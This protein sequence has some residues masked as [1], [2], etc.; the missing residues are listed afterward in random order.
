MAPGHLRL[1]GSVLSDVQGIDRAGDHTVDFG[2]SVGFC[3]FVAIAGD[4]QCVS[5]VLQA[6]AQGPGEVQVPQRIGAFQELPG[7]RVGAP[8]RR[9]RQFHRRQS[10]RDV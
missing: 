8:S 5:V 1:L 9:V 4:L 3:L 6:G 7:G 10:C 2:L